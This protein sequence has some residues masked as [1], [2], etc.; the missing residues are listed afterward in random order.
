MICHNS[1]FPP[2][3]VSNAH[4][5]STGKNKIGFLDASLNLASMVVLSLWALHLTFSYNSGM[6]LI[7]E[8]INLQEVYI[9]YNFAST[10]IRWCFYNKTML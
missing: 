1:R 8:T 2:I 5:N 4:F 6:R 7:A 10:G 9:I 3:F